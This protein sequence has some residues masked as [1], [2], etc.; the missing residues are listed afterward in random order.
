M[1][2]LRFTLRSLAVAVTIVALTC[3]VFVGSAC[4]LALL[5]L[6]VV[7]I[8]LTA[9]IGII[10][11]SAASRAFWIGF[12]V[13]GWTYV[14]VAFAPEPFNSKLLEPPGVIGPIY[15]QLR[16]TA[17]IDGFTK[18]YGWGDEQF[19]QEGGKQVRVVVTG[20]IVHRTFHLLVSLV[21]AIVG[22]FVG[23]SFYAARVNAS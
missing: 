9:I 16:R 15:G 22:G 19:A 14:V 18:S 2:G 10:Y 21:F 7:G 5:T 8:H 13:F 1:S 11:S 17:P 23:N 3:G 20:P 4:C 6:V 12:A